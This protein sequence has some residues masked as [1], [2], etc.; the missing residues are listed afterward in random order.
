MQKEAR[1][2]EIAVHFPNLVAES[3]RDMGEIEEQFH[4]ARMLAADRGVELFLP[5]L[6]A[7]ANGHRA[8]PFI[9]ENAVFIDKSGKVMP[10]HFLWHTCPSMVNRE[11][12][13]VQELV[14]G[15][16]NE[17]PLETIWQQ[18]E[19]AAFRAE[20]GLNDYAPCWSC[21]SA[22]CD[23]L[24]NANLLGANDC[25]GSNVPCGHCMWGIGW[26]KCL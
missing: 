26:L 19:Y 1:E 18:A 10:C 4:Q 9:E 22:P 24:V 3:I 15:N 23:D 2:K 25:Y 11:Q 5:P 14:F 7:R 20:A 8:C 6:H 13:H 21:T 17:Q 16:I 12:I